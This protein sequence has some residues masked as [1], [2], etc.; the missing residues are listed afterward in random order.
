MHN[1]ARD[2]PVRV[3]T[4][5]E[6]VKLGGDL[7]RAVGQAPFQIITIEAVADRHPDQAY[8]SVGPYM[9]EAIFAW[10]PRRCQDL[11][12]IIGQVDTEEL[13]ERM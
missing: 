4:P 11:E 8:T 9:L 13:T 7:D 5:E 2:I 1:E 6:Y 3:L 10:P 12:V